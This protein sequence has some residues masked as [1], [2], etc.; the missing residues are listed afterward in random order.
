MENFVRRTT[1]LI[2][3]GK[4]RRAKREDVF[5]RQRA[6]AVLDPMTNRIGAWQV[7][8]ARLHLMLMRP[9]CTIEQRQRALAQIAQIRREVDN[10]RTE[11]TQL[12]SAL[13]P[14][15]ARSS[16]VGD[17]HMGLASLEQRLA[18]IDRTN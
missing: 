14:K 12:V 5:I 1:P 2:I 11:L 10:S 7:E 8:I 15:A 3:D 9:Q 13:P 17:A 18:T 6:R 4:R 16:W